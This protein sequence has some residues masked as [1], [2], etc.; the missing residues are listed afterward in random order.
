MSVSGKKA[1]IEVGT[2][3]TNITQATNSAFN[4]LP[5]TTPSLAKSVE[6]LDDTTHIE[7]NTDMTMRRE[8]GLRDWSVAV[9]SNYRSGSEAGADALEAVEDAFD[10]DTILFVRYFPEGKGARGT[11]TNVYYGECKPENFD[12]ST[13]VA[14]LATVSSTL[15]ANGALTK[16]TTTYS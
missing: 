4:Q 1:V 12:V 16:A 10:N 6:L 11:P 7:G 5:S 14:G 8:Q 2:V 15:Q 3:S 13:D 9:E